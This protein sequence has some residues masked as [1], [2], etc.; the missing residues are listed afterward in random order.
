MI[1]EKLEMFEQ[2]QLLNNIQ[3]NNPSLSLVDTFIDLF[4][5][6]CKRHQTCNTFITAHLTELLTHASSAEYGGHEGQNNNTCIKRK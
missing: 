2:V 5:Q 6:I 1:N 3:R 4:L